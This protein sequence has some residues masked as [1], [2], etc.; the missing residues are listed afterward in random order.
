LTPQCP[1]WLCTTRSGTWTGEYLQLRAQ[2]RLRP[3]AGADSHHIFCSM[4]EL[5]KLQQLKDE[6]GELSSAD[7]KRYRALKRTAERELLMVSSVPAQEPLGCSLWAEDLERLVCS[8]QKPGSMSVP[9][10]LKTW[11]DLIFLICAIVRNIAATPVSLQSNKPVHQS[12][13]L[14]LGVVPP[15]QYCPRDYWQTQLCQCWGVCSRRLYHLKV[16]AHGPWDVHTWAAGEVASLLVGELSV[17]S[18]S[19]ATQ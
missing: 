9:L 19:G 18:Q 14:S 11:R 8:S 16:D 4:P 12:W 10:L 1:S 7:E 17:E 15:A 6:T 13:S 2:Y 5:Q 3:A